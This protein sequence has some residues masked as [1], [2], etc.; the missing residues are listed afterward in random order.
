MF[1]WRRLG[2]GSKVSLL[3]LPF[4]VVSVILIVA[5]LLVALIQTGFHPGAIDWD[6]WARVVGVGLVVVWISFGFI[7]ATRT[8]PNSRRNRMSAARVF[9][10]HSSLDKDFVR[11]LVHDLRAQESR[12]LVRRAE[13]E[14]G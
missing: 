9:I 4:A 6:E 8:W 12:Y 14:S 11:R 13:H 3:A 10:S 7:T 2:S 1:L 5:V